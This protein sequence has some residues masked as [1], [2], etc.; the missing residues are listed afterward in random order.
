MMSQIEPLLEELFAGNLY[1]STFVEYGRNCVKLKETRK[2]A[3][4]REVTI[5]DLPNNSIVLNIE[6][7]EQPKTLF[8]GKNGECKRC[9][10]ILLLTDEKQKILLFIEM[11]S[12]RFSNAGVQRQFKGAECVIDYCDAVLERFHGQNG[13]FKSYEK[14]FVIFYKPSLAKRT[15]QPFKTPTKND[16]PER[17]LK[18][19]SPHNPS[20]KKLLRL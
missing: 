9:D 13:L 10:Y 3:D 4:L 5:M 2:N 7:F 6:K 16:S 17:A 14:R 19:P 8:K 1:V 11:K 18:Y 12:G 20:I 15:T